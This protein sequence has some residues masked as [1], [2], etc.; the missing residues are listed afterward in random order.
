M[1]TH[2]YVVKKNIINVIES[3]AKMKNSWKKMF[4]KKDN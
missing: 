3:Q 4:S 1:Q 2:M